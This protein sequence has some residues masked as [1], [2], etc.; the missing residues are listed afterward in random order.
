MMLNIVRWCRNY[1]RLCVFFIAALVGLQVPGFKDDY[2]HALRAAM[3]ETNAAV[4]PFKDDAEQFFDGSLTKLLAH[5]QQSAD[6]VYAKGGD[7]LATLLQRSE[8]LQN[9]LNEFSQYPYLHLVRS[10]VPSIGIQVWHNYT[11]Q[12]QLNLEALASAVIFALLV[13][14]TI[15]ALFVLMVL[16]LMRAAHMLRPARTQA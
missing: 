12:I 10:P 14:W 6:P 4:A 15:E 11:P 9:A 3:V 8:T 13:S 7:N 2:G 5:Y 16:A 1:L